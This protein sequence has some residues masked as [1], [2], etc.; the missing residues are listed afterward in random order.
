MVNKH[1]NSVTKKE[2]K[3]FYNERFYELGNVFVFHLSLCLWNLLGIFEKYP[4]VFIST[5]A[6]TFA[7]LIHRLIICDVTKQKSR[8]IQYIIIPFVVIGIVSVLEYNTQKEI[9]WNLSMTDEMVIYG[10]FMYV[11]YIM[12]VYAMR[13]MIDISNL[14]QIRIFLI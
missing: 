14:L 1:Y 8:K 7:H 5:V 2:K 9:I 4:V 12:V 11:T 3:K 13:C 10:V 6:F